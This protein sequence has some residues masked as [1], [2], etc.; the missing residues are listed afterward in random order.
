MINYLAVDSEVFTKKLTV[1]D[2]GS[3]RHES[4]S[5]S[6]RLEEPEVEIERG[7]WTTKKTQVTIKWTFQNPEGS[8]Q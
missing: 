4:S 2:Y 5:K 6:G 1:R 7:G 3:R 8:H